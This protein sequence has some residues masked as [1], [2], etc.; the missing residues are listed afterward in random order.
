MLLDCLFKWGPN[1][2]K[3]PTCIDGACVIAV[4]DVSASIPGLRPIKRLAIASYIE[5][6]GMYL[7]YCSE[8]WEKITYATHPTIAAAKARARFEYKGMAVRWI[9]RSTS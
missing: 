1:V 7:F 4:A 6:P 8:D 5:E 3:I 2:D 9:E